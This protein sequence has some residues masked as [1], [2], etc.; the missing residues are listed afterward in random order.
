MDVVYVEILCG[1][2]VE[3]SLHCH[4][5]KKIVKCPHVAWLHQFALGYLTHLNSKVYA[6]QCPKRAPMALLKLNGLLYQSLLA[7]HPPHA[8]IAH[9]YNHLPWKLVDMCLSSYH[10]LGKCPFPGNHPCTFRVANVTHV[11]PFM[12]AM[13][14]RNHGY[15]LF[16]LHVHMSREVASHPYPSPTHVHV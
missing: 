12:C 15:I 3:V 9:H 1:V 14:G 2:S 5:R 11:A 10:V 16:E 13:L 8:S 4:S 6:P 7:S